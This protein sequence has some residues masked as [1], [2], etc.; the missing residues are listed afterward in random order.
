MALFLPGWIALP[1][2]L[3]V[4]FELGRKKVRGEKKVEEQVG[5]M[6]PTF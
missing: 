3:L 4:G 5:Q 6:G 1:N 2:F